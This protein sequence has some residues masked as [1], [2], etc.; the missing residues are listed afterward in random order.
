MANRLHIGSLPATTMLP[1]GYGARISKPGKNADSDTSDDNILF[2]SRWAFAGNIHAAGF[3]QTPKKNSVTIPFP[4]LPF[5]PAVY[6]YRAYWRND[7]YDVIFGGGQ[8]QYAIDVYADRM[9]INTQ[10]LQDWDTDSKAGFYYVVLRAPMMLLDGTGNV[11]APTGTNRVLIGRRGDSA[12]L[13]VSQPGKDVETCARSELV[14]D[15]DNPPTFDVHRNFW[16]RARNQWTPADPSKGILANAL[17]QGVISFPNQ[18]F[19]PA[20]ILMAPRIADTGNF[21]QPWFFDNTSDPN[22]IRISYVRV[23]RNQLQVWIQGG[24]RTN[25]GYA[26]VAVLVTDV[27]AKKNN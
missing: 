23:W 13:Y 11:P 12:G 3:W 22:L 20:I 7:R 25:S 14:F 27:E 18:G 15:S 1:A 2:D 26:P 10:G 6:A 24:E 5:V 16:L 9:E 19:L 8:A 4:A 21:Y 17:A